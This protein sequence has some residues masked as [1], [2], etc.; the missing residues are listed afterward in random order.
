MNRSSEMFLEYI[1][2]LISVDKPSGGLVSRSPGMKSIRIWLSDIHD[3]HPRK[4]VKN[5]AK[6]KTRVWNWRQ[7]RICK[8]LGDYKVK[9]M[10]MI[11][12]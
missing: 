1:E 6:I 5:S 3:T 11:R 10:E 9:K 8:A 4:P 7:T 12:S 2:H